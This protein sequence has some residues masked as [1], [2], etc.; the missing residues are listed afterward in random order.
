MKTLLELQ[1]DLCVEPPTDPTEARKASEA[2]F[3]AL[4]VDIEDLA[5]A[6]R[7]Y[8]EATMKELAAR[9]TGNYGGRP[10]VGNEEMAVAFGA[11]FYHALELGA[12][13]ERQRQAQNGS[14]PEGRVSLRE[15]C[16]GTEESFTGD[17]EVDLE[18]NGFDVSETFDEV[19]ERGKKWAD[20]LAKNPDPEDRPDHLIALGMTEGLILGKRYAEANRHVESES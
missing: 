17:V 18:A 11:T 10:A 7:E 8:A 1:E 2:A 9:A 4:G 16:D 12:A 19:V 15:V 13:W 6:A 20:H 14:A 3:G 5:A